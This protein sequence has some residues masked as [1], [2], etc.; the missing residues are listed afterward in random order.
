MCEGNLLA[1]RPI[2]LADTGEFE[3]S[4]LIRAGYPSS[5]VEFTA[6]DNPKAAEES[7][8]DC[9]ELKANCSRRTSTFREQQPPS[10]G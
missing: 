5:G 3:E 10:K 6:I 8:A 2:R 9:H 7:K 4:R 1:R